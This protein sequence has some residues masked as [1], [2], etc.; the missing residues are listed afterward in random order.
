MQNYNIR[1]LDKAI[2]AIKGIRKYEITPDSDNKTI[3]VNVAGGSRDDI[4]RA[5]IKNKIDGAEYIGSSE[6]L[7]Q[8][9][10]SK[11][12]KMVKFTHNDKK[13]I[14]NKKAKI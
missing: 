8:L 13:F 10:G 4:A 1:D 2:S 9:E 5:L 14:N 3:H 12:I 6:I 7:M 11:E